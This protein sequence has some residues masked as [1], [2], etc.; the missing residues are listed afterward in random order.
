MLAHRVGRTRIFVS[1]EAGEEAAG[2]TVRRLA[3]VFLL[4]PVVLDDDGRA[5]LGESARINPGLSRRAIAT[6]FV[7]MRKLLACLCLTLVVVLCLGAE[8]NTVVSRPT[9]TNAPANPALVQAKFDKLL[10]ADNAAQAEVDRWVTDN[11]KF[12]AQGGGI[13]K[14]D[15]RLKIEMRLATV[16]R[17]Y[18][19]FLQQ[20]P[21]HVSALL[22]YGSLL[23]DLT[24]EAAAAVQWERASRLAPTNPATWNN[25]ANH[26]AGSG[27]Q[28]KAFEYFERSLSL[29]PGVATY[30]RNLGSAIVHFR[31][32]AMT[33]YHL[34]E[35]AVLEKG[36][37][38]LSEAQQKEGDDF[39]LATEIA[40][41]YYGLQP[42]RVDEA[43]LAWETARKLALDDVE[44]DGARLHLARVNLQAGRY[45]EA[46]RQLDLI[47]YEGYA[48]LK[49][50]L[51]E[52][53]TQ[54]QTAATPTNAPPVPPQP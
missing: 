17:A 5:G 47:K 6:N 43:L 33:Y 14:A 7:A 25:L 22:A 11:Q 8:T 45:A 40:Q 31:T 9:T 23:N 3:W 41:V 20:H 44:Q 39:P 32:N 21:D 54:A 30:L 4:R 26:A 38:L 46:R 48:D 15:L 42:P 51:S 16:R 50:K 28:Q 10:A 19:E 24:D 12:S 13:D 1:G 35:Q 2:V 18:E 49:R 36:L 29:A 53:L 52:Q 34:S 37:K 27:D